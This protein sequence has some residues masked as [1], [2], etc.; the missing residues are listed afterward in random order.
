VLTTSEPSW[1]APFTGLSPSAFGK[2]VAQLRREGTD[3]SGRG[4]PWK[5]SLETRVLVVT[6]YWRTN[7]TLRQ[8]ALLFGVSKSAADR[9][10]DH[11]GPK[12]LSSH[13]SGSRRTRC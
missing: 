4:R 11:L 7:L 1:T 10:I 8:L 3:A 5:L 13:A 12:L 9:V 2:L 6:A